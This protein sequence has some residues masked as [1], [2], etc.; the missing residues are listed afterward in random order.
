V[1]R[2]SL[3]ARRLPAKQKRSQIGSVLIL[4]EIVNRAAVV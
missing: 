1:C 2:S 4:I 3:I